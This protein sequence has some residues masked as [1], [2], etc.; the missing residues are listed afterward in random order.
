MAEG[1]GEQSSPDIERMNTAVV[2][3]LRTTA[4][5]VVECFS[6][7]KFSRVVSAGAP[8]ATAGSS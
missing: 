7:S 8:T 1:K 3:A 4:A 6:K 5:R 2:E